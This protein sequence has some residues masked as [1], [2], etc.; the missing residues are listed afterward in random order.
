MGTDYVWQFT[1]ISAPIST[2]CPCSIWPSTTVPPIVDSGDGGAIELG[3]KFRVDSGGY[4]TGVRFY[5][6]AANTGTHIGSLWTTS[7][8]KL[9]SVTFTNETGSGWQQANF[10][11]PVP[12]MAGTDYIVSYYAPNGHYSYTFSGLASAGVDNPP[13][14]ALQSGVD[15]GNGVY[16][17]SS[18]SAFPS[19]TYGAANYWVDAVYFQSYSTTA[20][21][22][23]STNPT[24]GAAKVSLGGSVSAQ[25]SQPMDP[26]T[27]TA[28]NLVLKDSSNNVVSGTASYDGPSATLSFQP[29]T[30]LN[31]LTVYT[32]TVKGAVR[33]FLGTAMGTDSSWNFTTSRGCPCTIWDPS[34]APV[35]VDSG[36]AAGV[37]LGVK[38]RADFDGNVIGV[39]FYKSNSNVGTHIG[40]LWSATGTRLASATF[41]NESASGWQQVIFSAPVPVTAGTTYVASYFAPNGHYAF[42]Q[43]VFNNSGVD[44]APLHALQ[45]GMAG[46]DGVYAY[47]SASAFPS[48]SWNGSNYWV[49]LV[50][51]QGNTSSAPSVSLVTPANG[52]SGIGL[53]TPVTV[54]FTQPMDPSSITS[55]NFA[56]YDPSNNVIPGTLT[57]DAG[58]FALTFQPNPELA[59][60]SVYRAVVKGAV[61][62]INGVPLGS[63]YNW[64]F[65]TTTAPPSS[66]PGGPVLVITTQT[67][68][69]T[70]Y[71]SE[72][73]LAEGLNS[74][75]S[76]DIAG[77][78]SSTLANY[79]VVI[80][81]DMKLTPTQATMLRTWVT[82]GGNL[83]AMH[84]DPQ[85]AGLLGLSSASSTL[86]DSYL[87]VL[88]SAAPGLGIVPNV[89]QFHGAADLYNATGATM[90]ARLYSSSSTS[91]NYPAVSWVNAGAG[92]AAAFTYD[93]ARSIVYTRQGNPAWSGRQRIPYNDVTC[94]NC[95]TTII[96]AEDMFFGNA[97]FDPEPDWNNLNEVAIPQGDEQQRLLINLIEFMN[98]SRK[99]LPRFWYLPSGFKAAVIMTG[100]DHDNGGTGPRFDQYMA[101]SPAGCSVADWTCIRATS[102]IFPNT[103]IANYSTYVANGFEIANHADN[104]ISCTNFTFDSLDAAITSQLAAVAANYPGLPATKTNRTHCVTWTDYD[105]EPKVLLKHGIRFD[106]TY[107][108]WPPEWILDRPGMFTG[109]GFPMRYA[110]HTGA[111]IDVYQ[112]VTQMP[113][114]SNQTF[115]MT[116]DTLLDNALGANGFYG[117]FTANMHTDF[118][119]S[120]GSD[121]IVASAQARGVPVITSLQMLTWLDGRNGSKFGSISFANNVLTFTITT[122]TGARNIQ[123]MVPARSATKSVSS[124]T[125]NGSPLSFTKQ[126]IKGIQY[127]V[128]SGNAGSYRVTY[129]GP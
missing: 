94:P 36:D 95:D 8:S 86:S 16:N 57:Y 114:E 53:G 82:N 27:M 124:I 118:T 42:D 93:L 113:D 59:A 112:A 35:T 92:R 30:S 17:Y 61:R 75:T 6:S 18:T 46:G 120:T 91:T 122:A 107:Y 73:L 51:Y 1:T 116:I 48:S 111:P 109:S 63:D 33:N 70:Q 49:D 101:D 121:A 68:P 117:V 19:F 106:T 38:F 58:S 3:V 12:V 64:S 90:V 32:A 104:G 21:A 129:A 20:P 40:N 47:G 108:Y 127:A 7:G 66:G 99:P 78:S 14:H 25:F 126:T 55:A 102:Y 39:R 43:T 85:L 83:I 69:Y 81:G 56:V 62:N 22:V 60:V 29:G 76:Q 4:I 41:S 98:V 31:A 115:P 50:Y 74:F 110:D 9:A 84:P 13:M 128:F 119:T 24:S 103:P 54:S 23:S 34:N 88:T 28:A 87:A 45:S 105:S 79:D 5:K 67:N 15:G 10:S 97:S 72:I 125:V 123:A 100:D 80:L 52:A 44:N 11:S 2:N 65:T 77:V 71:L 26:T 96:R 89:I 37:E